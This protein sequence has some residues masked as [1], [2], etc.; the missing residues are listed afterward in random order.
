[1]SQY[2]IKEIQMLKQRVSQLTEGLEGVGAPGGGGGGYGDVLKFL[3]DKISK[4]EERIDQLEGAGPG[5][6]RAKGPRV[7]REPG[8]VHPFAAQEEEAA[9]RRAAAEQPSSGVPRGAGR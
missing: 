1:M 2:L 3:V 4:L 9:L 8:G 5:E 6:V 7:W